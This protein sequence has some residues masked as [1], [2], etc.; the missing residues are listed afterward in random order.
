[1]RASG[2]FLSVLLLAVFT[3]RCPAQLVPQRYDELLAYFT[4]AIQRDAQDD[5]AYYGRARVHLAMTNQS[6]AIADFDQAIAIN[7]RHSL[8]IYWRGSTHSAMKQYQQAVADFTAAYELEPHN[9]LFGNGLA[10]LLATC[11][12]GRYRDGKKA[13]EAANRSNESTEYRNYAFLD[14]LA[15]AYAEAGQFPEAVK[16]QQK[17]IE[18]IVDEAVK[19]DFQ[20][21]LNLYRAN[22]PYRHEPKEN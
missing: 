20:S 14:T 9:P 10:W 11:P 5:W 17:A 2:F 6:K 15:A 3:P 21:R 12:D 8:A 22:R 7:P 13:V 4:D 18:P 16:W 19:R 1:M